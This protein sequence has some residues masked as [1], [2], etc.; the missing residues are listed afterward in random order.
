MEINREIEKVIARYEAEEEMGPSNWG[1]IKQLLQENEG[2]GPQDL[3]ERYQYLVA[4]S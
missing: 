1:F 4:R 3:T 2:Q